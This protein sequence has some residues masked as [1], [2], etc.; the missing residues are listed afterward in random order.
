METEIQ[1]DLQNEIEANLLGALMSF[2]GPMVDDLEGINASDFYFEDNRAIFTAILFLQNSG[3]KSEPLEVSA[4]LDSRGVR[5]PFGD[6]AAF[7]ANCIPASGKRYFKLLREA[8]MRRQLSAIGLS[9][10]QL[11]KSPKNG[12]VAESINEVQNMLMA[13]DGSFAEKEAVHVKDAAVLAMVEMDRRLKNGSNTL[14]GLSTGIEPLDDSLGGL[15]DND[16]II[17]AARSSMGKTSMALQFGNTAAMNGKRVLM[18][19]M[20]MS[21]MQLAQRQIAGIANISLRQIINPVDADHEFY[22]RMNYSN[23]QIARME[24]VVDDS[25]SLSVAQIRAR[26]KRIKLKYGLDLIIVDQLSFVK[27]NAER[28]TDGYG[29]VTNGLKCLAKELGIPVVLLHQLN[30]DTAK[31]GRRPQLHDL[32]DSGSVEEDADVVILIHRPGYYNDQINQTETELIIA[33]NRMG[34]RETVRCGWRG[35]SASFCDHPYDDGSGLPFS[36]EFDSKPA[37]RRG[38]S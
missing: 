34:A 18:Y 38:L 12:S 35:E 36:Y 8:S 14:T 21:A 1:H 7:A 19:S 33:K 9:I 15:Q 25:G 16:L 22:D 20:E 10:N 4:E 27:F 5:I 6:L 28:K 29:Q 26:A 2:K 17:V 3:S 31:E 30:R 23:A 11:A 37:R 13:L 32:K 24:F